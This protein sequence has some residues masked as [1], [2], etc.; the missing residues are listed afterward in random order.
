MYKS[1]IVLPITSYRS[2]LQKKDGHSM[3]YG[4]TLKGLYML[5]KQIISQ[6]KSIPLMFNT[7]NKQNVWLRLGLGQ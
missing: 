1:V 7:E 5:N 6:I 2:D 4:W 3:E